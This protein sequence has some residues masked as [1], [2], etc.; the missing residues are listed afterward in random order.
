[1]VDKIAQKMRMGGNCFRRGCT[2]GRDDGVCIAGDTVMIC[3]LP[4]RPV[5]IILIYCICNEESQARHD[6]FWKEVI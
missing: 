6:A 3:G 4:R 1:M 2:S 5:S